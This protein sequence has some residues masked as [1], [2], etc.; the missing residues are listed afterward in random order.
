MNR[1]TDSSKMR[2]FEC[3]GV[4]FK[5]LIINPACWGDGPSVD[6]LVPGY[7]CEDCDNQS[8]EDMAVRIMQDEAIKAYE[9]HKGISAP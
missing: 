7:Q 9:K 5:C 6:V 3:G 4:M 2:C 1:L 8:F